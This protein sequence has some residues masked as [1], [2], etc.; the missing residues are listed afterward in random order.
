MMGILR[1]FGAL[2]LSNGNASCSSRP[3]EDAEPEYEPNSRGTVLAIDDEPAILDVLR[4]TLKENGFNVL[5]ALSG[6]KGLDLL[7]YCQRDVRLVVL[8]Y[9]MP[10]FN[11]ALTLGYVRK[12][13][14]QVKVIALT[15]VE[16]ELLPEAFRN[17]VDKL[18]TKPYSNALLISSVNELLGLNQS[19]AVARV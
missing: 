9:N 19:P 3:A 12:L 10:R 2:F 8:D 14:P 6:P 4:P 16:I 13:N 7:R 1:A 15:G 5:T 18:L 17:G 11:G